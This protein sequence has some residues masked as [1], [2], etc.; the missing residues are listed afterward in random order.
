[1]QGKIEGGRRRGQQIMRWLDG[2][3]WL[4]GHEFEQSQEDSW[5]QK[6]LV[7]SPWG[8]KE[9]DTSEHWT[10]M[11]GDRCQRCFWTPYNTRDNPSTHP[12]TKKGPVQNVSGAKAEKSSAGVR[13]DH[14]C[15]GQESRSLNFPCLM[16]LSVIMQMF[17]TCVVQYISRETHEVI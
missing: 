2:H 13:V 14:V 12:K 16:E 3:H 17:G 11:T 10:T 8:C 9:L 7:C 15:A 5:G 4:N 6:G 1:M